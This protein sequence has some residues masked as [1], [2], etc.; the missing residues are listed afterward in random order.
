MKDAFISYS[1]KN[2]AFVQQLTDAFTQAER[3]VWIDWEGIAHGSDWWQEIEEGIQDGNCFIFVI[4]PDSIASEVCARELEHALKFD[5]QLIPILRED[6]TGKIPDDLAKLDWIFFRDS[7]DFNDAF[8]QLLDTIDSDLSRTKLHTKFLNRALEWRKKN[9]DKSLLLTGNE[10]AEAQ[11]WLALPVGKPPNPTPVHGRFIMTSSQAQAKNQ[12]FKFMAV[13]VALGLAVLVSIYANHLRQVADKQRLLAVSERNRATVLEIEAQTALSSANLSNDNQLD[14]L[15]SAIKAG[16]KLKQL[17]KFQADDPLLVLLKRLYSSVPEALKAAIYNTQERNRLE[18]HLDKVRYVTFSPDSQYIV[19]ASSDHTVKIWDR[20]GHLLQ[21]LQHFGSVN[22]VNFSNDSEWLVSAAQDKFVRVWDTW[23]VL[24][25]ELAHE[26][27]ALSAA[28]S[29]DKQLIVGGF[30]DGDIVVWRNDGVLLKVLKAHDGTIEDLDFSTDG[31]YL[32]SAGSDRSVKVWDMQDFSLYKTLEGHQDRVYAIDFNPL[33]GELVSTGADNTLRFWDI[34]T[35][36]ETKKIAAHKNWVYDV[37][38][39]PTGDMLASAS[40]TGKVKLWSHDGTLLKVY[41]TSDTRVI[42]VNFSPDG[43]IL[44]TAAADKRVKLYNL[45][46]GTAMKILEGHTSGLKDVDFSPDGSKLASTGTDATI[47]IWNSKNHRLLSTFNTQVNVRDV[48]FMPLSA[49]MGDML[50]AA[51]YE[52]TLQFWDLKGR[53]QT[54]ITETEGKIKSIAIDPKGKFMISTASEDLQLWTLDGKK[55]ERIKTGH[56]GSI[57]GISFSNDGSLFASVSSA[58]DVKLWSRE[59]KLLHTFVG[60]QGWVNNLSFS[61][62]N[63]YLAT[64][65]SDMTVKVWDI[66]NG[67]L[68]NTLTGHTDWVWDVHFHPDSANNHYLISA[69]SDLIIML[70]DFVEGKA[71]SEIKGHKSWVRAAGFSPSGKEIASASADQTI[72]LWDFERI[73]NNISAGHN[74]ALSNLLSRGCLLLKDYLDSN[75]VL[76]DHDKAVCKIADTSAQP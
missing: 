49:N 17:P 56:K 33:G 47:R 35:G 14:A 13:A 42:G 22:V 63:H 31:R 57:N 29:P 6:V 20:E 2:K 9:C 44:A 73:I 45:N 21:S 61:P 36:K 23:G 5:K 55:L 54:T 7:E 16:Q 48:D 34:A 43:S 25:L 46:A 32:A 4:T 70:W 28:F 15:L 37:A 27:K 74:E 11:Q 1:R 51:T 59:G 26:G 30:S 19:T 76:S 66:E 58:Y 12:R 8:A 72:I 65:S 75:T 52:N 3:E 68:L 50:V 24:L 39:S 67:T 40:A 69:G 38:Y 60:H 18:Q 71:L 62:D 41:N 10:L 53:L 64:A